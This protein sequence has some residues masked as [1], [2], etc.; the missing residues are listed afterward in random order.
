MRLWSHRGETTPSAEGEN[1]PLH[2]M[3]CGQADTSRKDRSRRRSSA[4]ISRFAAVN[5][6]Q[7]WWPSFDEQPGARIALLSSNH[8]RTAELLSL[9]RCA[10]RRAAL[11]P[12]AVPL[13]VAGPEFM[14]TGVGDADLL[15]LNKRGNLNLRGV[16]DGTGVGVGLGDASAVVFLRIR[17]GVGEA[18]GDS[19]SEADVVLSAREVVWLVLC[20]GCFGSVGDSVGVPVN[21][22]D[23][24]RATQKVRPITNTT[25]NS[26]VAITAS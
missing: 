19:A 26:L 3:L 21:N 15:G 16:G 14:P 17:F 9:T 1:A 8:S 5:V 18:A 22:C 13:P 11:T 24:T 4:G 25:G 12:A 23:C 10:R 7:C 2:L 20:V 6:A